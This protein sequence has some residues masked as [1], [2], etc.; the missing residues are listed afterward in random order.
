MPKDPKGEKR[1]ADV[2]GTV[3]QVGPVAT[4]HGDGKPAEASQGDRDGEAR[5]AATAKA[6]TSARRKEIDKAAASPRWEG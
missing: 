1:S 3:I 2:D 6:P 4:D 5:R